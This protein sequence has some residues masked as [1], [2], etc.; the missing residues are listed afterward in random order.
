MLPLSYHANELTAISYKLLTKG[1][2]KLSPLSSMLKSVGSFS[3][4][5]DPTILC[6]HN[7]NNNK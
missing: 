2:Y 1:S 7:L 4:I 6:Q 5:L 3:Q